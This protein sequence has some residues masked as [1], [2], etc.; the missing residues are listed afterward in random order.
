MKSK[1]RRAHA[2]ERLARASKIIANCISH[3]ESGHEYFQSRR[4]EYEQLRI[5]VEPFESGGAGTK[6]L[7]ALGRRVEEQLRRLEL[8][9]LADRERRAE[10]V[11]QEAV[12]E[13]HQRLYEAKMLEA[14]REPKR[15]AEREETS[16][17]VRY[18]M[19]ND[20]PG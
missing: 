7:I 12:R 13:R 10:E 6:R 8:D 14:S 4:E 20:G 1:Q 15:P 5:D 9:Y 16:L 18:D 2:E 19:T 11:R 17:G 3:A